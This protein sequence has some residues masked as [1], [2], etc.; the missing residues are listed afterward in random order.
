M[1]IK[2]TTSRVETKTNYEASTPEELAT[3]FKVVGWHPD[4]IS[5][6]RLEEVAQSTPA[7][8]DHFPAAVDH[9]LSR[10]NPNQR[11]LLTTLAACPDGLLDAELCERL[12]LEKN[13][14]LA[15]ILGAISKHAQA[16][17]IDTTEIITA[18]GKPKHY[19]LTARFLE[20]MK[21][22]EGK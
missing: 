5:N 7:M 18:S 20:H 17:E 3:F 13:Q 9:M 2:I 11:N 16:S 10:V 8:G 15:G 1:S 22:L 21:S 12:G 6:G 4:A 19:K 14:Q